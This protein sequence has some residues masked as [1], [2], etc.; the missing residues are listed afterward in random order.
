MRSIWIALASAFTASVASDLEL[1]AYQKSACGHCGD[2]VESR[3][4]SLAIGPLLEDYTQ[5]CGRVQLQQIF[6]GEGTSVF[7]FDDN[8]PEGRTS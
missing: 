4:P 7:G 3:W 8:L 1:G 6:H 2:R 5:L